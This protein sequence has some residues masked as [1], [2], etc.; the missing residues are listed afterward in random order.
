MLGVGMVKNGQGYHELGLI[1]CMVIQIH[2]NQKLIKNL[3]GGCGQKWVWLV[4]SRNCKIDCVSKTERMEQ[5][6]FFHV[7]TKTGKLK[8]DS[9]IV[10]LVMDVN[11]D[12]Y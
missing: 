3:L 6:D 7:G 12:S 4:R 8:V 5:T 9:M 2:K 1:F 10:F 11:I